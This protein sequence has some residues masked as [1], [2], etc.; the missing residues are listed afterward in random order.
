MKI[1]TGITYCGGCN[2]HIDRTKLVREIKKLLPH[3]YIFTT[4][5]FSPWDIGIMVCGCPTACTNKPKIKNLA[6]QWVVVAGNSVD[7]E[8]I[9]EEKLAERVADKIKNLR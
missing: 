9:S 3:E 7:L 5:H 4:Q 2:P 8:R 6:H 1:I